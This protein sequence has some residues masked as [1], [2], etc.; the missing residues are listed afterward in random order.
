MRTRGLWCAVALALAGAT[1]WAA[2]TIRVVP[3]VRDTHVLVSFE[4]AEGITDDLRA[5]IRSGLTTSFTYTVELRVDVPLWIDRTVDSATVTASVQY[6]SLTRRHH[7][8]R[9]IDGRIEEARVSEDEQVVRSWMTRFE[10]LR[11]FDTGRLELNREYYVRVRARSRP[12]TDWVLWRW[13]DG[14]YGLAKFTFIP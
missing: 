6:D 10:Q 5:A 13:K 4:L 8:T 3:L 12:Q 9:Q 11:L 7:L 1:L 2:E 14:H